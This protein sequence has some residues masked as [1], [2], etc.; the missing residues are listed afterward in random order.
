MLTKK[1]YAKINLCIDVLA[2]RADGMHEVDMI[3]TPLELYDELIFEHIK[4]GNKIILEAPENLGE[5][6]DNLIFRAAKLLQDTYNIQKGAKI[7][8]KK[9]IP[10]AAGLAGGSS[11]AAAT[12]QALCELWNITT[13]TKELEPLA[14]QLGADIPYCLYHQTMRATGF[15]E[16]LTP[17]L[18][19]PTTHVVLFKVDYGI[20]TKAA[21]ANISAYNAFSQ[22]HVEDVIEGLKTQNYQNICNTLFNSFETS[23]FA[24]YKDLQ[25]HKEALSKQA[26]AVLLSGSGPTLF[27]FAK[28]EQQVASLLVYGEMNN[29]TTIKT[30]TK[31]TPNI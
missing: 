7:T 2:K 28:D 27:A 19:M 17:L 4:D 12:L 5:V 16:Q 20:S 1:A 25:K 18:Q 13:T 23:T 15:G 6:T 29:L 22:G 31:T 3:L 11:D 24:I 9:N 21:Y 14:A 10:V 26:D 8:L 30:K